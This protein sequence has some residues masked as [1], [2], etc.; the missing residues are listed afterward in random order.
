MPSAVIHI[1]VAKKVKKNLGNDFIV[2]AVAPDCWRNNDEE[3]RMRTHF[4]T[5]ND[6]N[7][8]YFAFYEKYKNNISNPFIL[9]YLIHLIT[10]F[11]YRNY[12]TK[13]SAH[14]FHLHQNNIYLANQL[15]NY[16]NLDKINSNINIPENIV[17]EKALIKTINYINENELINK[18]VPNEIY[19]FNDVIKNINNCSIFV[20]KELDKLI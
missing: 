7:E 14:S 13:I 19:D 3:N 17:N 9:G 2:G 16:F 20:S 5:N 12:V 1:C 18:V 8:N 4:S 11:Y 10:D 15:T 6:K